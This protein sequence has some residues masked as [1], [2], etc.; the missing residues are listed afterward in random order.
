MDAAHFVHGAFLG[1]L[2]CL[3]RIFIP[4][5]SGRKRFNVLGALNALN[6]EMITVTNTTYINSLSICEMLDK[7]LLI[8]KK[9][10]TIV[11][12][13][14]KYQHCHLVKELGIE[15]LFL[16]PYSPQLNLIERFWKLTKNECLYCKYYKS[17]GEFKSA[18]EDFIAQA[19]T[20]HSEKMESLL[21]WNFQSFSKVELLTA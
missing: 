16:P 4:S 20:L 9:P 2:W 11:L 7:L 13:N 14:A 21:T 19:N 6:N 10:I 17:F 12:D 8:T 3:A 1:Y 15:L 18:I 5:P